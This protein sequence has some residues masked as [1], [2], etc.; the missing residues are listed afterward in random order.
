MKAAT[1]ATAVHLRWSTLTLAASTLLYST[2]AFVPTSLPRSDQLF[3]SRDSFILDFKW[4]QKLDRSLSASASNDQYETYRVIELKERLRACGL[5]V[6]GRQ[7]D[8]IERL[9]EYDAKSALEG[10]PSSSKEA[11]TAVKENVINTSTQPV[12]FGGS[13]PLDGIVIEAGKS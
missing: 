3:R 1:V 6:G 4:R 10:M 5:K 8:L 11:G 9:R 12:Q 13:I 7:A 2:C